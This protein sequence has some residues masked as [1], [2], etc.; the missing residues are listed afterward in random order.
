M[1]SVVKGGTGR[2]TLEIVSDR[3]IVNC[4]R[5]AKGRIF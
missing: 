5:E 1:T 4:Y 3:N 2:A